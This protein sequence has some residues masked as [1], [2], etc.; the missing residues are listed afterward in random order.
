MELST[1]AIWIMFTIGILAVIIASLFIWLYRMFRRRKKETKESFQLVSGKFKY[2][3]FWQ[4]Y[5]FIIVIFTGYVVGIVL[6]GISISAL[7]S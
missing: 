1:T 7:A 4:S 3:E 5:A 2:F 6:L